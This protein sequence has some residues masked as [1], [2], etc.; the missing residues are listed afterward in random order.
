MWIVA[1]L[2]F[3]SGIGVAVRMREA[4]ARSADDRGAAGPVYGGLG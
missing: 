4:M 2:T 3:A 1:A